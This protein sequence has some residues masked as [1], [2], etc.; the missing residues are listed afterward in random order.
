[1][2]ANKI[3]HWCLCNSPSSSYPRGVP[4]RW[5]VV[6]ILSSGVARADSWRGARLVLRILC[7]RSPVETQLSFAP[8]LTPTSDEERQQNSRP[9]PHRR[10]RSLERRKIRCADRRN[11][12]FSL[13]ALSLKKL[14]KSYACLKNFSS[15]SALLDEA[16]HWRV[17]L[18]LW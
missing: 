2:S 5:S 15:D 7:I 18:K 16:L 13:F 17:P 3:S 10:P 11:Y 12:N 6:F 8:D 14:Q 9:L 4:H 1:M